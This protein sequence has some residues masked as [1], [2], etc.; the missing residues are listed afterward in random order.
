VVYYSTLHDIVILD[1]TLSFINEI[2]LRDKGLLL[3]PVICRSSDN[4]LW[5]LDL[6]DINIKKMDE[7]GN[8]LDQSPDIIQTLG[9]MP[10][11]EFMVQQDQ[12][13]YISDTAKG[14]IIF[15]EY[16]NYEKTLPIKGIT[17]FQLWHKNIVYTI[18]GTIHSFDLRTFDDRIYDLKN[19]TPFSNAI[20]SGTHLVARSDSAVKL[21]KLK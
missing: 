14:I 4:N 6:Q 21:Y 15:D 3:V 10:Q 2:T 12:K 18:N 17:Y 7:S 13:L 16:G 20:L 5:L 8:I 9:Y 1:N 19:T 11:P